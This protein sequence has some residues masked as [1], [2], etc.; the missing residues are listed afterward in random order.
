MKKMNRCV[1]FSWILVTTLI[2]GSFV[3]ISLEQLQSVEVHASSSDDTDGVY[4]IEGRLWIFIWF[5][6]FSLVEE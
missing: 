6:L 1:V 3:L 4:T 5:S 2:L